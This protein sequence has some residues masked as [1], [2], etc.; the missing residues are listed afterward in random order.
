MNIGITG[1]QRLDRSE[2]WPSVKEAISRELDRA[3]RPLT[4]ITSLAI[5]ADQLA[6]CLALERDAA[7]K[8]I[9][10]FAE[11]E[12]TFGEADLAEYRRLVDRASVEIL[13]SPGTDQD[14]YLAAGKRVVDLSDLLIAV[15]DGEPAKGK[16]GTAD[17]V[18][19]ALSRGVPIAQIDPVHEVVMKL[20]GA[21]SNQ[22]PDQRAEH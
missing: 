17:V 12:R 16:G 1:H 10:P 22:G 3:A 7:I 5:G 19:Y 20:P 18:A 21:S 15:W 6:A 14:A 9:L 4:L 11:V 8:A 13:Q 2:A